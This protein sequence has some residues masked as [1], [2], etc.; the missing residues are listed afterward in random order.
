VLLPPAT[1]ACTV[2]QGIF[3]G[4]GA[5][6]RAIAYG[7]ELNLAHPPRP[8]DPKVRWEPVW[9]VKVR[10]K[11]V[12]SAMLGMGDVGGANAGATAPAAGPE[13]DKPSPGTAMPKPIDV[14]RGI[15]G[16]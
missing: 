4:D 2:P 13:T 3:G 11:T 12:T 6:L 1:T 7:S 15:L 10:V 8:A 16:R 9:A 5:M 14:L